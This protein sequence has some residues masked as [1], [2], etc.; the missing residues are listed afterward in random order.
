M[1]FIKAELFDK[2]QYVFTKYYDRVIHYYSKINGKVSY[3]K[4]NEA[5][6]L[7]TKE[8]EILHS[9]FIPGLITPFWIRR[10]IKY[11]KLLDYI[12]TNDSNSIIN[13]FL[14]RK[15][16]CLS[17]HQF[18]CLLVKESN[19]SYYFLMIVNHICVDGQDFKYL[20]KKIIETYNY[21]VDNES[22]E[23]NIKKGSRSIKQVF[24]SLP[25]SLK[26]SCSK[27]HNVSIVKKERKLNY[28]SNFGKKTSLI[29][30]KSISSD[31]FSLLKE[32]AKKYDVTINDIYLSAYFISLYSFTKN[33]D[34]KQINITSMVDLRRYLSNKDSLGLTNLITYMPI[35]FYV[36]RN[37]SFISVLKKVSKI[38]KEKKGSTFFGLES[39]SLLSLAYKVFPFPLSKIAIKIGYSNPRFS[40]SNIGLLDQKEF[41]FINTKTVDA[42][43][44]GAIKKLPYQQ[45]ST[46]T[47]NNTPSFCMAN[48]CNKKNHVFIED[49]LDKFITILIIFA[50]E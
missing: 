35:Q 8:I 9:S 10:K 36:N 50:R 25:S 46:T 22:K 17:R 12:E 37:E 32:K 4:L 18:K 45:I 19:N 31:D 1:K 14:T 28:F 48:K 49:I 40:L 43:I 13:K 33:S 3:D 16:N 24:E 39:L 47:F 41:S 23:I 29:L 20:I 42:Y 30:R 44:T 27:Y 21:L 2:T 15:I 6:Y 7:V 34:D 11:K 26:D 5:I 38:T